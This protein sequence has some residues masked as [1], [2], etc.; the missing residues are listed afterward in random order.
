VTEI[1]GNIIK[2][3]KRSAISRRFHKKNDNK[4]IAAWVLDLNGILDVL[5][6]RSVTSVWSLLNLPF[7]AELEANKHVTDDAGVRHDVANTHSAVPDVRCD[8]P[9]ANTVSYTRRNTLKSR[10]EVGDKDTMVSTSFTMP[11]TE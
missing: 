2:R 5:N 8:S 3:N 9:D 6:V 1:Q 7:Q 11:V 4:A 10:E